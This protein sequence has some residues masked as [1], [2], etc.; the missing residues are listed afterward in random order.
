MKSFFEA[1][2]I[3]TCF[4]ALFLSYYLLKKWLTSYR[5]KRTDKYYSSIIENERFAQNRREL[6]IALAKMKYNQACWAEI[7]IHSAGNVRFCLEHKP[8]SKEWYFLFGNRNPDK[9]VIAEMEKYGDIIFKDDN[10]NGIK[11]CDT[12]KLMDC[13]FYFFN[14][15]IQIDNNAKVILKY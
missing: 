7:Y 12:E 3:I 5:K 2:L 6:Q 15:V 1:I 11:C 4:T 9:V 14:Q 10:I 8:G 13:I